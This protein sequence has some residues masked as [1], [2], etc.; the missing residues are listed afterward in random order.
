[1]LNRDSIFSFKIEF[2]GQEF[3]HVFERD[4]SQ[5]LIATTHEQAAMTG[6]SHV[7]QGLQGIGF[8]GDGILLATGSGNNSG[9]CRSN[10]VW[11]SLNIE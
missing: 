9:T 11:I 6:L 1:M 8:W 4:E 5:Q 3:Q 2:E 7:R 10:I